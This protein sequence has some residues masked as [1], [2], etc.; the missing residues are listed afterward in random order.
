MHSHDRTM[1]AKLGF[2]D[3]DRQSSEHDQAC[4][5]LSQPATT[6]KLAYMLLANARPD[7]HSAEVEVKN[8]FHLQKGE[9][10]YATTVGFIDMVMRLKYKSKDRYLVRRDGWESRFIK[11]EWKEGDVTFGGNIIIEV[12]TTPISIGDVLRQL[13]LYRD[14]FA[15]TRSTNG[16]L[17][18]SDSRLPQG[19]LVAT[20]EITE[21]EE[22]L[23]EQRHFGFVHLGDGFREWQEQQKSRASLMSI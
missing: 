20:W 2:A 22:Q 1:L 7:A 23:L 8:E 15:Q 11:P 9:G 16:D 12:K 14:Y 10:Q 3:P 4:L 6:L 5:Y 21:A 17:A 18:T 13:V 19:L